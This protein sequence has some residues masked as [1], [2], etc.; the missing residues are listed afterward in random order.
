MRKQF[1]GFVLM[2][3]G[4]MMGDSDNLL[5]PLA[6]TTMGAVLILTGNGKGE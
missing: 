3:V 5:L 6:L 1:A 2:C 4:A